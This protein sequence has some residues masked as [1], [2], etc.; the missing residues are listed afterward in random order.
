M[1]RPELYG[2]FTVSRFMSAFPAKVVLNA[3]MSEVMHIFD[4]TGAWNLPVVDGDGHYIGFVSKS[5]I[6]SAYRKVLL[7][8][9]PGD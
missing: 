2:R 3:P 9:F 4:D 7:D 1:F 5:K 6:F 8:N